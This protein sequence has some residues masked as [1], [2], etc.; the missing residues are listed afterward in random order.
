MALTYKHSYQASITDTAGAQNERRTFSY[1]VTPTNT[2][3]RQG[4]YTVQGS[5]VTVDNSS[6]LSGIVETIIQNVGTTD[7]VTVGFATG[8]R[9]ISIAPG[10]WVKFNF[11]VAALYLQGGATDSEN[12]EI[13][14][15]EP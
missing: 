9:P 4:I 10:H 8:V 6:V 3:R 5:E 1:S 7:T 15:R 12:V 11:T 2:G 14:M 13:I